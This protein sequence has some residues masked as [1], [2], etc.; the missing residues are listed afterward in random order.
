MIA[1][2][3]DTQA[4]TASDLTL[5][6]WVLSAET[7]LV[8]VTNTGANTITYHFQAY[9]GSAWTDVGD[10]GT[11]YHNTLVAGQQRQL[12]IAAGNTQVRLVGLAAGGSTLDFVVSAFVERRNG[13][14]LP[15]V[16]F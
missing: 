9:D 14:S 7:V 15:L 11:D 10:L 3:S 16:R 2:I 5:F 6:G 8:T 13:G 4:V 12:T 1:T